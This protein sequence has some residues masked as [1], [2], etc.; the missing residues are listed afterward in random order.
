MKRMQ[1]LWE[2]SAPDCTTIV[3]VYE[4]FIK[5][6]K[7]LKKYS[8]DPDYSYFLTDVRILDEV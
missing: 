5:A 4:N 7:G 8:N 2:Q 6:K 1:L 3:G